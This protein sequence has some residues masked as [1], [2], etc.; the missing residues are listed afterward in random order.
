MRNL[1]LINLIILKL[2]RLE[3]FLIKMNSFCLINF[4]AILEIKIK[5]NYNFNN[6]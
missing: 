4:E 6:N 5:L 2:K 1:Y 3:N